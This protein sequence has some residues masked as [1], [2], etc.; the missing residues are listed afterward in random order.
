MCHFDIW[1]TEAELSSSKPIQY[2]SK[3]ERRSLCSLKNSLNSYQSCSIQLIPSYFLHSDVMAGNMCL[4]VYCTHRAQYSTVQRKC[5]QQSVRRIRKLRDPMFANI[6]PRRRWP[7]DRS[8]AAQTGERHNWSAKSSELAVLEVKFRL[9][10]QQLIRS[11]RELRSCL[12]CQLRSPVQCPAKHVG[13][14]SLSHSNLRAAIKLVA[15]GHRHLHN[16]A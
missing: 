11:C 10:P 1:T 5:T 2:T 3:L 9:S 8:S 7:F 4:E 6:S 12:E 13:F 14:L 16:E 15:D